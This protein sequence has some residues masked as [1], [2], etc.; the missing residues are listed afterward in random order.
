[1]EKSILQPRTGAVIRSPRV[2]QRRSRIRAELLATGARLFAERGI[3]KVSVEDLIDQVG[4]S[5]RTFYGFFANKQE[6]AASLL[7]PV[8]KSALQALDAVARRK[9]EDIIAAIAELYLDQWELHSDALQ[10]ISVIDSSVL[11]YIEPG[12]KLFGT[13]LLSQLERA[14]QAGRLRND[15]AVDSFRIISRTALPLLKVYGERTDLRA[16]YTDSLVALL[17]RPDGTE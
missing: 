10:L 2:V 1:M 17:G 14:G 11:P 6:V 7:N 16:I 3:V 4:I 12:H 5:R 8:L 13:A 9:P 15:S